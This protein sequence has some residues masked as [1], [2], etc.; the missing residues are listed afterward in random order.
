MTAKKICERFEKIG[1]LPEKVPFFPAEVDYGRE[2]L[3]AGENFEILEITWPPGRFCEIHDHG[4]S[5]ADIFISGLLESRTFVEN[6]GLLKMTEREIVNGKS[7][8]G[9]LQVKKGEIHQMG[10][11]SKDFAVSIHL[12][13]DDGTSP[14]DGYRLFDMVSGAIRRSKGPAYFF[15]QAHTPD[16]V[17]RT[18]SFADIN[19]EILHAETALAHLKRRIRDSPKRELLNLCVLL[20]ERISQGRPLAT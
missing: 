3:G 17:E 16:P 5:R 8:L 20:E 2:I 9:F 13:Y 1:D 14:E 10:N 19:D 6:N 11:P 4:A 7:N 18:C 12:Y 15:P